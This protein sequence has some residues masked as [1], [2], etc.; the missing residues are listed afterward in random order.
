M[1]VNDIFWRFNSFG[2][3]FFLHMKKY[4]CGCRWHTHTHTYTY[5]TDLWTVGVCWHWKILQSLSECRRSI[6]HIHPPFY[7]SKLHV[8]C[9]LWW[10][11]G[12]LCDLSSFSVIIAV[13]RI[14][15]L[16]L[17]LLVVH[18]SIYTREG[19]WG[20]F[21]IPLSLS[22]FLNLSEIREIRCDVINITDGLSCHFNLSGNNWPRLRVT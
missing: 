10:D 6:P 17:A 13:M 3:L 4:Q 7:L 5:C 20:S 14:K 16:K 18:S 15:A 1:G 19:D 21:H 12:E 22:L 9:Y 2:F 11:S 8:S